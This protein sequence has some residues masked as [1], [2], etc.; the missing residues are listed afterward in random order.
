MC[1]NWNRTPSFPSQFSSPQLD[2]APCV[3]EAFPQQVVVHLYYLS[4]KIPGPIRGRFTFFFF[5]EPALEPACNIFCN[6][7]F[8]SNLCFFSLFQAS[9]IHLLF[10]LFLSCMKVLISSNVLSVQVLSGFIMAFCFAFFHKIPDCASE[11]VSAP[12]SV[13]CALSRVGFLLFNCTALCD[14][15]TLVLSYSVL[16]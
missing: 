1:F 14:C 3:L 2:P 4:L 13:S 9:W 10:L 8:S 12:S 6:H 16:L 7:F 5:Q 11:C 15:V